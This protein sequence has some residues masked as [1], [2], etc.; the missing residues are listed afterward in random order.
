MKFLKVEDIVGNTPVL[1]IFNDKDTN[2]W[3]KMENF[4]PTGSVKDRVAL[5]A[6]RYAEEKQII[7]KGGTVI[8]PTSGN[9]GIAF[10][11]LCAGMG[12][13]C[14]CVVEKN[15][16][17][18]I[19]NNIKSYGAIVHKIDSST[20]WSSQERLRVAY[21]ISNKLI[22]SWVFNQY[23]NTI[24]TASHYYGIGKELITQFN[25]IDWIIAP[26]STGGT[27]SGVSLAAK[28]KFPNVKILAVEPTGSTIFTSD[29]FDTLQDSIGL[30]FESENIKIS[31]IDYVYKVNDLDALGTCKKYAKSQ[32]V[33]VGPSTGASIFAVEELI[34][35]NELKGNIVIIMPDG[36]E[37][38]IDTFYD[39]NWERENEILLQ[40]NEV[41]GNNI[42]KFFSV[43]DKQYDNNV[44]QTLKSE[45]KDFSN[46]LDITRLKK[47]TKIYDL[48]GN[49]PLVKLSLDEYCDISN[50]Y[51][52]LEK[53]NPGGSAKDRAALK[54]INEA[55]YRCDLTSNKQ[56]VESSSGN[57]GIALSMFGSA[58]NYKVSCIVESET[59]KSKTRKITV[60][61]GE[62]ITVQAN[63]YS[64]SA[65]NDR[66]DLAMKLKKENSSIFVPF[67]YGNTDN[68]KSH[69]LGTGKEIVDDLEYIDCFIS[70]ISTGGT[71]TGCAKKLKSKNRDTIIVGVEPEGSII[72]GGNLKNSFIEGAGL[73]FVPPNLDESVI[74]IGTKVN[75]V[76]A[77]YWTR[78]IAKN[79][80]L[81][82]G[83]STGALIKVAIE[84]AKKL[85][86]GK[87]IVVLA[88]DGGERYL[89]TVFNDNWIK[90]NLPEL[91]ERESTING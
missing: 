50:I 33:F 87:N 91:I 61:G 80:G 81:S 83:I 23:D 46:E 41:F 38:Y 67:Q 78:Y 25:K 73:P 24:N 35:R 52:K 45:Y 60:F 16:S 70:N 17:E 31:A 34:K 58:K 11:A 42:K 59:S 39:P 26:V 85:G 55:E 66:I 15:I 62:L 18:N 68:P 32:G 1:K 89:D 79:E 14:I 9:L 84:F 37:K 56:I 57:T 65:V 36:G 53:Y 77:F 8:V 4:N 63:P 47:A 69:F 5:F 28:E 90:D 20:I 21:S 76:D 10:S 7:H 30:S 29:R 19:E 44:I 54:M 74:D 40:K 86:V 49:T 64:I 88:H 22:N 6:L 12:Y 82:I 3:L 48:V 2:V 75:D 51:V 27:I 43:E 72:F 13:K 71:I